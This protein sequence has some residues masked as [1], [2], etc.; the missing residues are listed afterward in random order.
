MSNK[1]TYKS[2]S[3]RIY[4]AAGMAIA[5]VVVDGQDYLTSVD[6]DA[7]AGEMMR[8]SEQF[9]FSN[10]QR[11]AAKDVWHSILSSFNLM[12]AMAVGNYL[13][14]SLVGGAI[15][16]EGALRTSLEKELLSAGKEE[17]E[18][19]PDE[20]QRLFTK[21]FN[22]LHQV[23]SHPGVQ[24]LAHSLA[25]N[26]TSRRQLTVSEISDILSALRHI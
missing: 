3:D 5:V 4:G 18:L 17:C 1:L 10:H 6:V 26:F 7:P 22:Y 15:H 21:H 25:D 12:T 16:E 8:L 2:E 20:S 11:I 13:C 14:R 9:Y 24:S 23:F 19:D